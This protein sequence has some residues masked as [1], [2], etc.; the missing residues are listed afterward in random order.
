M[1]PVRNLV[2]S[3]YSRE[4]GSLVVV[5]LM[6]APGAEPRRFAQLVAFHVRTGV[7]RLFAQSSQSSALRLLGNPRSEAHVELFVGHVDGGAAYSIQHTHNQIRTRTHAH[8]HGTHVRTHSTVGTKHSTAQHSTQHTIGHS[9]QHNTHSTRTT[10]FRLSFVGPRFRSPPCLSASDASVVGRGAARLEHC[11]RRRVLSC[12]SRMC[13]TLASYF[14][15]LEDS[16]SASCLFRTRGMP[17]GG[18]RC[19]LLC[20]THLGQWIEAVRPSREPR[21]FRGFTAPA[22]SCRDPSS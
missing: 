12:A 7:G 14:L 16:R 1:V 17:G 9:T 6:V 11:R 18:S 20:G 4:L 3:T 5:A 15:Q 19:R 10:E 21:L 8:T 22:A 2:E 13:V